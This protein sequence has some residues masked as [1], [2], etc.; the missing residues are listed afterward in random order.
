VLGHPDVSSCGLSAVFA[1]LDTSADSQ[2]EPVEFAAFLVPRAPPSSPPSTPPATPPVLPVPSLDEDANSNLSGAGGAGGSSITFILAGGFA[3][4]LLFVTVLWFRQRDQLPTNSKSRPA[5]MHNINANRAVPP[6]VTPDTSSND[7]GA[8]AGSARPPAQ[9]LMKHATSSFLM[10][11]DPE[12]A[13]A[14]PSSKQSRKIRTE[15]T[16]RV[17]MMSQAI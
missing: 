15:D 16:Q 2:L 14:D 12:A 1:R 10:K 5:Y 9:P 13:F 8:A 6:E 3:V 11:R 7:A 17:P 4:L